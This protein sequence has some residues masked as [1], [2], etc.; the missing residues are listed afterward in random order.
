MTRRQAARILEVNRKTVERRYLRMAEIAHDFHLAKLEDACR[1][2]GIEGVFQL[3]ELETFEHHRKLKPVTMSVLIE[4]RSY[5][6]VHSRAGALPPRRPLSREELALL[7]A[8][9]DK[10]G[11]RTSESDS[12]VRS[13]F[14]ALHR[15]LP[16]GSPVF[17]QTDQKISYPELCQ[18]VTP[19]REFVHQTISSK[20]RR[21]CRNLLFP[22]NH[23]LAMLR[24]GVSCLVRRNWGA[25][26]KR[27]GLQRHVWIWMAYRNYIRSVT[28][29]TKKTPAQRAGV[30]EDRYSVRDL[31][32]WRWPRL[33]ANS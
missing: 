25:C 18:Q 6:M 27:E 16:A 13:S 1:R 15:I 21:D 26:K 30:C 31:F 7:M 28:N 3:D 19:G 17:L 32:R 4:R 2:G 11:V 14:R 8:I 9:E 10:E 33:M 23:T 29:E 5:F 22:I 24:D 20:V 12:C